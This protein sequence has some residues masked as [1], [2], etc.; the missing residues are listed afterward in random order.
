MNPETKYLNR[1]KMFIMQATRGKIH[2]CRQ[3][4]TISVWNSKNG[5]Q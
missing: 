5:L 3:G 1:N 2:C 4:R